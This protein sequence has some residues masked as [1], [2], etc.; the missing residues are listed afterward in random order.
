MFD[1]YS[2]QSDIEK[3]NECL[4]HELTTSLMNIEK[5]KQDYKDLEKRWVQ[6]FLECKILRKGK[7]YLHVCPCS[8]YFHFYIQTGLALSTNQPTNQPTKV[9][10]ESVNQRTGNAIAKRKRTTGQNMM[11]KSLHIKLKIEQHEPSKNW[12]RTR[13]LRKSVQFLLH[14]CTHHVTLGICYFTQENSSLPF[15]RLI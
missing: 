14:M 6:L 9:E 5:I 4:K 7:Y 3:E 10:S 15:L 11:Y 1:R 12:E 2:S 8:C 13:V